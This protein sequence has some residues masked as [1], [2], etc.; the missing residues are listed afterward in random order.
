PAILQTPFMIVMAYVALPLLLTWLYR[1]RQLSWGYG[2]AWYWLYLGIY[3]LLGLAELWK[4]IAGN[5]GAASY[6]G[7]AVIA[8][9]AAFMIR[10]AV[11]TRRKLGEALAAEQAAQ[12]EQAVQIQTE[13]I[14]RAEAMKQQGG[15]AGE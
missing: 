3:L 5:A 10:S 4:I 9:V 6:A 8:V 14:M 12:R 1:E 15:E 7:V 2:G 13:A 11:I